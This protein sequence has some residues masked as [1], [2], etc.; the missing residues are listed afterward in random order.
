MRGVFTLD[1]R[2]GQA[3]GCARQWA[4]L[5]HLHTSC[6]SRPHTWTMQRKQCKLQSVWC[7][8]RW[9]VTCKS[10]K[11]VHKKS[12]YAKHVVLLWNSHDISAACEV[13]GWP[14]PLQQ[15][16]PILELRKQGV[17]RWNGDGR[18]TPVGLCLCKEAVDVGSCSRTIKSSRQAVSA[19][20]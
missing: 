16:C 13:E 15:C 2:T 12:K 9:H 3:K 7:M 10:T 19:R 5:K 8:L 11:K 4:S 20:N 14:A 18:S 6:H 17:A 1:T